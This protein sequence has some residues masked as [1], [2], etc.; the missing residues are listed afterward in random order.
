MSGLPMSPLE[1]RRCEASFKRR[2]SGDVRPWAALYFLPDASGESRDHAGMTRVKIQTDPLPIP[3]PSPTK[4]DSAALHK[5]SYP[6]P[7]GER[8]KKAKFNP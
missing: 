4:A 2:G 6:L 5:L 7:G 1:P 8:I 3:A